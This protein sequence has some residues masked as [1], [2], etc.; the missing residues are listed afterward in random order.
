MVQGVTIITRTTCYRIK[1]DTL[2]ELER[3]ILHEGPK[4]GGRDAAASTRWKIGWS[5]RLQTVEEGCE[6]VD[7]G[8]K[9]NATYLLPTWEPPPTASAETIEAW[10]TYAAEVLVHERRHRKIAVEGGFQAHDA[11]EATEALESCERASDRVDE[12]VR[13]VIDRTRERQH[14]FDDAE[15]GRG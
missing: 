13:E 14:A 3:E 12:R 1:G 4:V 6:A 8:V 7:P 11:I 15:Y 10:K 5:Y 9:V 2:A